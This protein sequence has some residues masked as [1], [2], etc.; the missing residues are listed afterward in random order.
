M[1]RVVMYSSATTDV[2]TTKLLPSKN[3]QPYGNPDHHIHIVCKIETDQR[4]NT[5]SC[6]QET[7]SPNNKDSAHTPC[8]S[9]HQ[10]V[11]KYREINTSATIQSKTNIAQ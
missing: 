5:V 2:T 8:S 1:T 6:D 7:I 9:C 10:P 4:H 11:T 3:I